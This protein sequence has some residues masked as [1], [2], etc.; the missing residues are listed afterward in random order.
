LLEVPRL[1]VFTGLR[2]LRIKDEGRNP[3]GSIKD[4]LSAVA[5]MRASEKGLHTVAAAGTAR[6]AC[7]L[8]VLA[9]S[10]GLRACVFLSAKASGSAAVHCQLHGAQVLRVNANPEGIRELCDR[11]SA[12]W[13]WYNGSAGAAPH[14]VEGIKTAGHE[15]AE[16]VQDDAPEWVAVP[17]GNGGAIAAIWKGMQEMHHLGV[18]PRRPRMLGV[19][20]E[21]AAPIAKAYRSG[22]ELEPDAGETAAA[23]IGI[24]RPVEWR[25]AIRAVRE[26]GGTFV[27]VSEGEIMEAVWNVARLAGVAVDGAGAAAVAGIRRAAD[28]RI[29]T[30]RERAVAVVGAAGPGNLEFLKE[31]LEPIPVIEP[32][33]GKIELELTRRRAHR[34]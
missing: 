4:R 34:G 27:C 28:E 23:E 17:V 6:A 13:G 29:M 5:V 22:R 19:Q 10:A 30:P 7:S 8:A 32:D 33:L 18:L 16:A 15:I 11:A 12:E 21:A 20:A 3:S 2:G 14:T 25:R 24:G 1:A 9:V 26:S 31:H